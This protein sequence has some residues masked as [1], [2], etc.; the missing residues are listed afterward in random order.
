MGLKSRAPENLSTCVFQ[1]FSEVVGFCAHLVRRIVSGEFT[2][3]E[4][5]GI[6]YIDIIKVYVV[7]S[8]NFC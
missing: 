3:F 8:V 1:K 7:V 2:V 4:D 6:I 5:V